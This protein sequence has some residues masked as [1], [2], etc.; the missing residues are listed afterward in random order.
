MSNA[1]HQTP[2][3]NTRFTLGGVT[4]EQFEGAAGE[5]LVRFTHRGETVIGTPEQFG[6]A[7]VDALRKDEETVIVP[8]DWL[9]VH[10]RNW[11]RYPGLDLVAI[12]SSL[13]EVG[14]QRALAEAG[15]A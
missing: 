6:R 4:I 1:T 2:G 7:V 14:R 8:V 3:D 9:P 5:T 10:G 11:L 15:A 12:S 13:D